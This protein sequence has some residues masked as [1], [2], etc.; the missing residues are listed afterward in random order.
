MDEEPAS[1]GTDQ[2]KGKVSKGKVGKGIDAG[3]FPGSKGKS[4]PEKGQGKASVARQNDASSAGKGMKGKGKAKIRAE[5]EEPDEE[6]DEDDEPE[7]EDNPR[8]STPL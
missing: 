5:P 8:I 4:V 6:C 1:A 3:K 2:Q 7:E